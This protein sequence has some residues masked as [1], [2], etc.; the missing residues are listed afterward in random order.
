VIGGY[1]RDEGF[2]WSGHMAFT[3]QYDP[4]RSFSSPLAFF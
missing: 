2:K 3:H 1:A 4:R